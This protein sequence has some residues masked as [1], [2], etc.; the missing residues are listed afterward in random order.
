MAIEPAVMTALGLYLTPEFDLLG[1]L[2][3]Q[4]FGGLERKYCD[5]HVD[6]TNTY[7]T[8]TITTTTA[9]T[10][11]TIIIIIIIILIIR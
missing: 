7:T 6:N 1:F 8:T 10:T 3:Y 9:T 4:V 11:T 2:V 5:G